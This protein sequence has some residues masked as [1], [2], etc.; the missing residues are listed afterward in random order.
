[1]NPARLVFAILPSLFILLSGALIA[2]ISFERGYFIDNNDQKIECTIENQDWLRNPTSFKY[3]L[4]D[5]TQTHEG[6]LAEVKEFV[7]GNNTFVRFEV[8]MDTS[9]QDLRQLSVNRDPEWD[10]RIVFLKLIVN[11]SGK[12]YKYRD[13][14]LELF[15]FSVDNSPVEQLV[16]KKVKLPPNA[17]VVR[18]YKQ[19][20]EFIDNLAYKAQLLARVS[21]GDPAKLIDWTQYR[22]SMLTR[23]FETYNACRG[24]VKTR[25]DKGF[26][27]TLSATVGWDFARMHIYEQW[28]GFSEA[29]EPD[30]GIQLGIASEVPL[31]FNKGKWSVFI[32]PTFQTSLGL[33]DHR[34]H[35]SLEIPAG[36]RHYFYLKN[37]ALYINGLLVLD[38]PFR[39]H[40]METAPYQLDLTLS[41]DPVGGVAA[42][43]GL[44]FWRMT[45][46]GRYYG[47]RRHYYGLTYEYTK[48]SVLTS[49]R[50]RE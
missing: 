23:Y 20:A 2:Q 1:M 33:N 29:S 44:R 47:K 9:S 50:L 22:E 34:S 43:G 41:N 40:V 37:T 46:E 27:N 7:A 39:Y 5:D 18:A 13:R 15:F 38:V 8:R 28:F 36:I 42:G 17:E 11:G 45:V 16:Y 6:T 24:D 25:A 26:L 12:L 21:C 49:F 19:S 30:P 10:T 3:R 32:Q 31:P 14:L 35:R 4:A 48:F